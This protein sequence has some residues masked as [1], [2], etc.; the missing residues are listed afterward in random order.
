[1]A[2]LFEFEA[3]MR[4][5]RGKAAA[6]RLRLLEDKVP[7]VIYGTGK[8]PVT[9]SLLHKNV[10]QALDYEAVYSRILTINLEG[11]AEKVVIKDMMRHPSRP[12]VLHMDFLRINTSEKLTMNV[13]LHFIGEEE[14]PGIKEGGVL[15]KLM[16]ELEISC[17]PADLPEFID[18]DV[19]ALEMG[20]STH[21]SKIKLPKGVALATEIEDDEHDQAVA[22][23][24]QPKVSEEAEEALE[25][26]EAEAAAAAAEA[27]EVV[28]GEGE[29][30]EEGAEPAAEGEE[31]PEATK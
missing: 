30:A 26:A 4:S 20:D 13:P 28:E 15:S 29:A 25:A 19:S 6:R 21:L 17:L 2:E 24:H 12:R 11:Q 14:A 16:A 10:L 8:P 18:V 5:T 31:K 7:A 23:V 22:N 27:G 9:I 3:E 1:M